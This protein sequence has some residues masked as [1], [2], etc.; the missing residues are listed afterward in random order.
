MNFFKTFILSSYFLLAKTAYAANE[1]GLDPKSNP[2][3]INVAK[4]MADPGELLG[5]VFKNGIILLFTVGG[6]GFTIM[7]VWGA[8][9]WILSGG[10]KEKIAGARKRIVTAITGLVLLS[11]TFVVATVIG[12]LLGLDSLRLLKFDIPKLGN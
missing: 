12:H 5:T 11:L 8:I 7:F 3:G 2:G 1:I 10:D 4:D 6:L 9:D